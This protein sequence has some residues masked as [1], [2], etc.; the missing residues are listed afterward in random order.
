M[1]EEIEIEAYLNGIKVE[2]LPEVSYFWK[3]TEIL[4]KD[5]SSDGFLDC[6]KNVKTIQIGNHIFKR[7]I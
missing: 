6:F 2:K 3:D 1:N 4:F 5:L 7:E